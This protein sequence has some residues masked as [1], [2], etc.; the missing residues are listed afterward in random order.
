MEYIE[1]PYCGEQNTADRLWCEDCQASLTGDEQDQPEFKDET[2]LEN[3]RRFLAD[4]LDFLWYVSPS[5]LPDINV[6]EFLATIRAPSFDIP[7][8]TG[9]KG[10]ANLDLPNVDLTNVDLTNIDLPEI[11]VSNINMPDVDLAAVGAFLTN[12]DLPNIDYSAVAEFL[13]SIDLPDVDYA[14]LGE[15]LGSIDLS[16]VDLS[17]LLDLL[18]EI[19]LS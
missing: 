15:L 5:T 16:D 18:G 10:I 12:I 11:D 13:A 8:I 9:A 1:C 2:G 14:A 17:P 6:T 4:L 7:A 3:S 19:D